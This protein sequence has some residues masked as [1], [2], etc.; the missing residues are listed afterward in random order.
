MKIVSLLLSLCLAS[1]ALAEDP[2]ELERLRHLWEKSISKEFDEK[3]KVYL[4][5]LE[6]LQKKFTKA[7]N[8]TAA[9]AVNA[10][11]KKV[12]A[13]E[14]KQNLSSIDGAWFEIVNGKRYLK[15]IKGNYFVDE[16]SRI[17]KCSVKNGI[18]TIV[19][20]DGANWEL[21]LDPKNPDIMPAQSGSRSSRWERV[22][23]K[24]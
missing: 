1:V 23:W 8:L 6:K 2:A 15:V 3:N 21:T 16:T 10:E 9:V 20:L 13:I 24:W 22:Q 11:M 17:G 4:K 7:N 5:S 12:E 18:L 14:P 19:R